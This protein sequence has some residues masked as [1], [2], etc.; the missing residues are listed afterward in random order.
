MKG[1][2][3]KLTVIVSRL[4]IAGILLLPPVVAHAIPDHR[5]KAAI[6]SPHRNPK[7]VAR[8]VY[9]HP[10]QSLRFFGIRPTQN[11]VEILPGGGY[12]T[13]ILAPYL[14]KRGHYI[15]A[16]PLSGGSPEAIHERDAFQQLVT[17]DRKTY[18]NV[19]LANF[20]PPYDVAP[21]G[22]ADV[23][24]TFRNLHNW[25]KQG[26]A[27]AVI[28][29]FYRSLKPGGILGIEDHRAAT[30]APQDPLAKSG[31]VR[32][33]YA[34]AL[35]E[36]AGFKLVAKSEIGANPK[37]TKD[38]PAGVWTLPPTLRLGDKDRAK[39]LAIGESDRFTLKFVKP[40]L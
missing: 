27:D 38:Y 24:L 28:Q 33:D 20:A 25:L 1:R 29:G 7:N 39:Y 15:A 36:K 18:A 11:V 16:I 12:W 21:A 35:I 5:L 17:S 14:S 31:Y 9:R 19:R 13:E 22:T 2:I 26:T 10:Y 30:N 32:Q 4:L 6:S 34:I 40:A 23:I 8:D 37:D 3:M